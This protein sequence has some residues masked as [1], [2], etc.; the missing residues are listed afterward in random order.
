MKQNQVFPA[1]IGM[2]IGY[3]LSSVAGTLLVYNANTDRSIFIAAGL[4][5]S[6]MALGFFLGALFGTKED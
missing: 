3:G 2:W 6:S 4:L 5:V 1:L